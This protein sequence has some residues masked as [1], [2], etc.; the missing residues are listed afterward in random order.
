M[1]QQGWIAVYRSVLDPSHDLHPMATGE[2]ACRLAAWVDL[3]GQARWKAGGELDRGQLRASQSFLATR[4][5][6]SRSK[7]RR[8]LND[9]EEKGRIDRD[10]RAGQQSGRQATVITVCNYDV[11]QPA[12]PASDTAKRPASGPQDEE[13]E[14]LKERILGAL[15]RDGVENGDSSEGR[16]VKCANCGATRLRGH[17]ECAVCQ[18]KET[19]AA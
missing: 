5:N 13:K 15:T 3:L 4:W 8:F 7:V 6:W 2:S 10:R 19:I 12:R 9:M 18:S 14:G 1:P 11:Y 17:P 16:K